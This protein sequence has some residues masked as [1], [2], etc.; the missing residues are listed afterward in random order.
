MET[1]AKMSELNGSCSIAQ[2]RLSCFPQQHCKV[3]VYF[4][5]HVSEPSLAGM[6]GDKL[7]PAI[8]C[9]LWH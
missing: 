5:L 7:T 2:I 6:T 4:H 3:Q 9:R 1:I 8:E